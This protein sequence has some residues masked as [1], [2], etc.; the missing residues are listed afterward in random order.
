MKNFCDAPYLYHTENKELIEGNLQGYLWHFSHFIEAG[1][2][3]IGKSCYTD[4][5]EVT[6]FDKDGRIIFIVLN[7]T[8]EQLRAYI[9]LQGQVVK[10]DV[11]PRSIASGIIQ[12]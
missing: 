9:R 5:L 10:I 1:A 6:A 11:L 8:E 12:G 2:V 4:K 3:R 7:R